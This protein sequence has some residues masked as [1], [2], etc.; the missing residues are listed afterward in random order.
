MSLNYIYVV[1]AYYE[2]M[3]RKVLNNSING[4]LKI[5]RIQETLVYIL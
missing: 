4:L 5:V 3:R 1:V 2:H